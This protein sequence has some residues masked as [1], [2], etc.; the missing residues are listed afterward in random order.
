[1]LLSGRGTHSRDISCVYSHLGAHLLKI[2]TNGFNFTSEVDTRSGPEG[3]R[4]I[5]FYKIFD[6][7]ISNKLSLA[8][9]PEFHSPAYHFWL[10][11]ISKSLCRLRRKR[12]SI[13]PFE[14]RQETVRATCMSPS[15]DSALLISCIC[16]WSRDLLRLIFGSVYK[17]VIL[18]FWRH[19]SCLLSWRSLAL[20]SKVIVEETI[21][22]W[23][24]SK[25]RPVVHSRFSTRQ[26]IRSSCQRKQSKD[27]SFER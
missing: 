14:L 9:Q 27:L 3:S 16:D 15:D 1:M 26:D 5:S 19:T 4:R 13:E 10:K 18:I 2:F 25:Y 22:E 21:G 6:M 11:I 23:S 7:L 17:N 20:K 8:L 24:V 12:K